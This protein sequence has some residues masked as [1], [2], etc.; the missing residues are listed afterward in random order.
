MFH[1]LYSSFFLTTV[2][3]AL[4]T[5]A[6]L[7]IWLRRKTF[8]TGWVVLFTIEILFDAFMTGTSSM[9][10]TSSL[11]LAIMWAALLAGDYRYWLLIIRYFDQPDAR[12]STTTRF[13]VYIVTFLINCLAGS[14]SS[15]IVPQEA[16]ADGMSQV[17]FAYEVT[18]VAIAVVVRVF[19]LPRWLKKAPSSIRAWLYRATIFQILQYVLWASADV[20]VL[21]GYD[22]GWALRIVPNVMYYGLFVP[23][24]ALTA[25]E[26]VTGQSS[27]G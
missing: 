16:D 22:A 19:L 2:V 3:V 11:M 9:W 25:P 10:P 13:G 17:F 4:L 1:D 18:F 23:F 6:G 8:F 15:F 7:A 21:Q 20:I 5:V 12:P 27:S 14:L 24:M 26:E